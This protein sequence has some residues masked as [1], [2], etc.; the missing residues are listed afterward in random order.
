MAVDSEQQT[1]PDVATLIA[2]LKRVEGLPFRIEIKN[3]DYSDD[4]VYSDMADY[5]KCVSCPAGKQFDFNRVVEEDEGETA[6]GGSVNQIE[7]CHPIVIDLASIDEL[8]MQVLMRLSA[9]PSRGIS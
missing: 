9:Q 1:N 5:Y 4:A 8:L 2:R 3:M 7:F 6:G